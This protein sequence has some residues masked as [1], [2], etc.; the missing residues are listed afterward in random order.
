[1]RVDVNVDECIYIYIYIYLY[2]YIYIYICS[3]GGNVSRISVPAHH[4][5][6][7]YNPSSRLLGHAETAVLTGEWKGIQRTSPTALH[8][9][10]YQALYLT[11]SGI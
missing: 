8:K 9:C 5:M 3:T 7:F 4:V 6:Q 10:L 2:M 1:M 11:P